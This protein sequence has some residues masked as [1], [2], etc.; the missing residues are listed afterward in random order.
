MDKVAVGF[1][2]ACP[3]MEVVKSR[4]ILEMAGMTTASGLLILAE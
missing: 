2:L 4:S 1:P 3:S